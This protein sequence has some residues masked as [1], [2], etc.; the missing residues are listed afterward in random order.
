MPVAVWQAWFSARL[1]FE[2]FVLERSACSVLE[3]A[4]PEFPMSGSETFFAI[5]WPIMS[6][7]V[8]IGL[9]ALLLR[10]SGTDRAA[11]QSLIKVQHLVAGV[12]WWPE[13][14]TSIDRFEIITR[15][16]DKADTHRNSWEFE[17]PHFW[18]S[19]HPLQMLSCDDRNDVAY[20]SE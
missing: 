3:G 8:L 20:S 9:T 19:H 12:I 13:F 14:F 11:Q 18:V 2:V 6:F 4:I 7:G 16:H 15:Q 5:T 1:A 17:A 10:P